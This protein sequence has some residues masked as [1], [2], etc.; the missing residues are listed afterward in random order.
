[1]SIK[2][3]KKLYIYIY[4]PSQPVGLASPHRWP[5]LCGPIDPIHQVKFK[6]PQPVIGPAGM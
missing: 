2:I 1:M 4:K 6:Q 3:D 5:D